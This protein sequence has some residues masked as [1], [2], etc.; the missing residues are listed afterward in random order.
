M[1]ASLLLLVAITTPAGAAADL[2][3]FES[4]TEIDARAGL[5]TAMP[6]TATMLIRGKDGLAMHRLLAAMP[7]NERDAAL[8]GYAKAQFVET[9]ITR[10]AENFDE[11]TG[12]ESI[13]VEG[14]ERWDWTQH[15]LSL[16]NM[17]IGSD[18][19][20]S[21]DASSGKPVRVPFPMYRLI[22]TRIRLP[23]AGTFELTG[24]DYD[25]TLAGMHFTR[26]GGIKNGV[27]L[28]EGGARSV[29]PQ[30]TAASARAEQQA[31]N[32]M[33]LDVP[34]FSSADY[35]E[36]AA[37]IAAV[38]SMKFSTPEELVWRGDLLTNERDYDGAIAD[39][40]SAFALQPSPETLAR[41]GTAWY[42]KQDYQ[43]ARA[44]FKAALAK[45]PASAAALRGLGAIQQGEGQYAEAIQNLTASA[46]LEPDD[47]FMLMARASAYASTR[48]FDRALADSA[49][50]LRQEPD[51]VD[52]HQLRAGIFNERGDREATLREVDAMVESAD[53]DPT[54]LFNASNFYRVNGHLDEARA[55]F[56]KLVA[57]L[58]TAA[59]YLLRSDLH[60]DGDFAA[61]IADLDSALRVDP[62]FRPAMLARARLLVE[63]GDRRGAIAAYSRHIATWTDPADLSHLHV[64]RGI[65][66]LVNG[67][68]TQADQDFA[69]AV[70]GQAPAGGYNTICMYLALADLELD[71]AHAACEKALQIEPSKV[72]YLGS[73]GFV[74]FQLGRYADAVTAFDAALAVK[75]HLS[76]PLYWRGMA[77]NAACHCADGDADIREAKR[78]HPGVETRQDPVP[79]L[80]TAGRT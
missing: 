72:D 37:D 14:T 73:M 4:H 6:V 35:R 50:V 20:Y 28:I 46:R 65:A 7:A 63:S 75:P 22:R 55:T 2:P 62:N 43:Q 31:L 1:R 74:L 60:R 48:D 45:D 47:R 42:W 13:A 61:R 49:A 29:I 66:Y 32:E 53:G 79:R 17:R 25:V 5:H 30:V 54:I 9:E 26:H 34:V 36:T 71:R 12:T 68:R 57:I 64:L 21:K 24:K 76:R 58:P 16:P 44:D 15:R 10:L 41:R 52:A 18:K 23:S 51:A 3:L 19:D 39:Y 70:A 38:R 11:S 33:Y 56:D 69:A 40:T 67:Q 78:L 59:N 8:R 27:L 80:K 77:K